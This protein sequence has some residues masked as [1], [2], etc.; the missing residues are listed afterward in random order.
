VER[1]PR[2]RR[3]EVVRISSATAGE[4]EYLDGRFLSTGLRLRRQ[5]GVGWPRRCSRHAQSRSAEL[6]DRA[7]NSDVALAARPR[8]GDTRISLALRVRKFSRAG[9]A[10]NLAGARPFSLTGC[11]AGGS[12]AVPQ[13]SP[14]PQPCE[15][16]GSV[17]TG[18]RS[19]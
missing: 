14:L 7:V 12:R 1:P 5:R 2:F 13:P 9:F 19:T 18:F 10:G 3:D 6:T 4:N 15:A 16:E 17:R 8:L 11:G